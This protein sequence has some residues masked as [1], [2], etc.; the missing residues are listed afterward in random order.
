MWNEVDTG[1]P[2]A[3]IKDVE[4]LAHAIEGSLAGFDPAKGLSR[5]AVQAALVAKA[6]A[7]AVKATLSMEQAFANA[8]FNFPAKG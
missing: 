4:A 1:R 5:A 7:L 2:L 3:T 6:D 8:S